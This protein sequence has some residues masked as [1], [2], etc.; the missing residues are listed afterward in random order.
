MN[1]TSDASITA[2]AVA[3]LARATP[4]GRNAGLSDDAAAEPEPEPG[5]R[6]AGDDLCPST[7]PGDVAGRRALTAGRP[8]DVAGRRALTAG[9][10][11]DARGMM[12]FEGDAYDCERCAAIALSAS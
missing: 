10:P 5:P 2:A 3:G 8:G 9:R 12:S 11:G 1:P 6:F 7:R 4:P